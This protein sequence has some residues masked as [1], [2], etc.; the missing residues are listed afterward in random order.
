MLIVRMYLIHNV[1]FF[2]LKKA[3]TF[4]DGKDFVSE[5]HVLLHQEDY[6]ENGEMSA[7]DVVGL[8]HTYEEAHKEMI[9]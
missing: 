6:P 8:F 9:A 4:E 5:R 2:N 3:Q 1:L 7:Y